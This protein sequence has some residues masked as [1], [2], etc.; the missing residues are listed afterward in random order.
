MRWLSV[1][2]FP[3]VPPIYSQCSESVSAAAVWQKRSEP[4]LKQPF[5]GEEFMA[6]QFLG[7]KHVQH[8]LWWTFLFSKIFS[9][10]QK[11]DAKWSIQNT[12]FFTKKR[13]WDF[14]GMQCKHK[15]DQHIPLRSKLLCIVSKI[16]R[17][18]LHIN[19][20]II[21]K[22]HKYLYSC[23]DP[24]SRLWPERLVIQYRWHYHTNES[25]RHNIN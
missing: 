7:F 14:Q 2:C 4:D 25:Y 21:C 24:D 9:A 15:K 13:N 1:T 8:I 6:D 3:L 16:R 17:I 18:L 10:G 19:K 5:M 11:E 22:V 12:L 20:L 23:I